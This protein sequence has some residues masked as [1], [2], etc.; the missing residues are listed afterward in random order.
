[1]NLSVLALPYSRVSWCMVGFTTYHAVGGFLF[2]KV[3]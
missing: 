1:M 3:M 2:V